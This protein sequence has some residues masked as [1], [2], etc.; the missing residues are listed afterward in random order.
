MRWATRRGCHVDRTA[1]AWLIRRFLD[2]D[3]DRE[4]VER[5]RELFEE[6]SHHHHYMELRQLVDMVPA[7]VLRQTPSQVAERYAA[8]WRDQLDLPAGA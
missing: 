1:Y 6:V 3:A 5:R 7:E 4:L 2:P 8:G